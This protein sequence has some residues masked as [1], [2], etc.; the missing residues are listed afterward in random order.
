DRFTQEPHAPALLYPLYVG[1][2]KL[3]WLLGIGI[4]ELF[5]DAS[6]AGRLALL[7]A[8]WSFTRL[9]SDDPKARRTG[10]ILI[11]LSGGLSS[12]LALA[13]RVTGLPLP[14]T[15]RDLNDPELNPF[16][17]LYTAPHLMFG[18]ARLLTAVRLY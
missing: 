2:G 5:L 17:V 10:L 14:L 13:I 18:L 9:L 16:P 7:L 6:T 1:L 8:T 11:A 12:V 3:A 15:G 4:E